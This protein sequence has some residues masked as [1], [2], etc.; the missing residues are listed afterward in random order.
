MLLFLYFHIILAG[1][2][3]RP[4]KTEKKDNNSKVLYSF[5]QEETIKVEH[6]VWGSGWKC[7]RKRLVIKW[8]K[9][10]K[11]SWETDVNNGPGNGRSKLL[12]RAPVCFYTHP[13]LA[14]KHARVALQREG[15]DARKCWKRLRPIL[16]IPCHYPHVRERRQVQHCLPGKG[17]NHTKKRPH[18][19]GLSVP[20]SHLVKHRLCVFIKEPFPYLLMLQ[21]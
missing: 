9:K 2:S 19:R 7:V 21:C 20:R 10:K 17:T 5:L 8:K 13:G 16:R 11:A 3:D 1:L 4:T 18:Q 12:S 14:I 15:G 6:I